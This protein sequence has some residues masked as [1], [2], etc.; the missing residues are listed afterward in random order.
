MFM[1]G[2]K[3]YFFRY[4]VIIV[5]CD[6]F[7]SESIRLVCYNVFIVKFVVFFKV[8]FKCFFIYLLYDK[9]IRVVI[10]IYNIESVKF[11]L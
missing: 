4:E 2:I 1:I 8:F 5:W 11:G 10:N 9:F 6:S 3:F 7:V